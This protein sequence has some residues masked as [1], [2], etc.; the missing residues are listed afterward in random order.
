MTGEKRICR[1]MS[2]ASRKDLEINGGQ[3]RR[4]M[5]RTVSAQQGR[6]NTMRIVPREKQKI[7]RDEGT[8]KKDEPRTTRDGS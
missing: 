8:T 1:M 7:N 4:T 6:C 2:E 3:M 5:G